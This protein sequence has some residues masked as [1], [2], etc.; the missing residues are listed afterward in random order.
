VLVHEL[1]HV[2]G[3]DHSCGPG[4]SRP[5][6]IIP[7]T[8]PVARESVMYPDPLDP[9]R[10]HILGPASSDLNTLNGLYPPS[11]ASHASCA[12]SCDCHTDSPSVTLSGLAVLVYLGRRSTRRRTSARI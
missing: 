4:T 5:P 8:D 12:C 7:C 9:D 2:L 6:P 3:L 1:G 11:K 10:P